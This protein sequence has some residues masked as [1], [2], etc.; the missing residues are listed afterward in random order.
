MEMDSEEQ[1][2]AKIKVEEIFK[3]LDTIKRE[4]FDPKKIIP[5]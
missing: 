1:K 4:N 2:Q 5:M 3:E